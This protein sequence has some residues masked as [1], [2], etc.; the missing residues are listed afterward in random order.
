M[1][2]SVDAKKR[3]VIATTSD[4]V[5]AEIAAA[6]DALHA[7]TA[8]ATVAAMGTTTNLPASNLVA[9]DAA[10]PTKAEVDTGIDTLKTAA[11]ARLDAIEAKI[12]AILASIKA[13]SL[14][15]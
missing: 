7:V 10:N 6:I 1:S 2:L 8:A 4:Q 3:L 9:V 15:A 11:E 5:G 12:D 14:M 13:A